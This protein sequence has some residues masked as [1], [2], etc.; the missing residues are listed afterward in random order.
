MPPRRTSGRVFCRRPSSCCIRY[1]QFAD[2]V[3]V[4]YVDVFWLRCT[5]QT[6]QTL[7]D[8]LVLLDMKEFPTQ[9]Y[10]ATDVDE[11]SA[12]IHGEL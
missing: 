1:V 4:H 2:I 5:S 11:S 6:E 3:C 12:A 10:S 8:L 9:Q 7:S